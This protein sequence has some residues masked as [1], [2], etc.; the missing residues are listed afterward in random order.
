MW[1]EDMDLFYLTLTHLS[2]IPEHK[3]A[4]HA[5]GMK[6][7]KSTAGSPVGNGITEAGKDV[8]D[9]AYTLKVKIQE[10][11]L[12]EKNAPVL[13]DMKHMSLKSRLD[14]YVH[15]RLKGYQV[16]ILASHMG[17]T[18][19]SISEWKNALESAQLLRMETPCV[20]IVTNR[21]T[22]GKWGFLN[23]AF[24][25]NPW[26]INLMDEDIEEVV[27]SKGL[28]GVSLDVRILGWQ[29]LKSK[30]DKSELMS[31]EDFRYFFP[32]RYAR[33]TGVKPTEDTESWLI[34]GKDERHP[35]ALCFN[36]IHILSVIQ[37]RNDLSEPWHY[38]CL[39]SDFDGLI[40]PVIEC[41]NSGNFGE[42]ELLLLRWL[43]V[44]PKILHRRKRRT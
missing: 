6:L 38:I 8:I 18:G 43:P 1:E 26:T 33:I 21:K 22:A 17:V 24:S 15:R 14:L 4:T 34:P 5:H 28:I 20:E 23:K 9:K 29:D 25:F 35:L 44:G 36:I 39:G 40:N 31:L 32:E 7:L 42:L 30:G 10:T 13:I 27:N 12:K 2:D 11:P 37:T 41:R 19:Y 3:L 16:P